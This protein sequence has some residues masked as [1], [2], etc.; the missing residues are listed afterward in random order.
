MVGQETS[1]NMGD[2]IQEFQRA[3]PMMLGIARCLFQPCL[4]PP[5]GL[6]E[7]Q[8]DLDW[9]QETSG[10]MEDTAVMLPP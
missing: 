5:C 8:A 4:F 6:L 2:T 9:G 3:L 1:E 10:K 7:C